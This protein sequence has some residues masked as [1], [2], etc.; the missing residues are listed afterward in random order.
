MRRFTMKSTHCA[1]FKQREGN[2]STWP[3]EVPNFI[4]GGIINCRL[5]GRRVASIPQNF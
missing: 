3:A 4:T 1:A 5:L 2:A